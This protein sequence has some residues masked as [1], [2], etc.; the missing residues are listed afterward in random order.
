MVEWLGENE[1]LYNKKKTDYKNVTKKGKLWRDKAAIWGWEPA[2][3]VTWFRSMRTRFGKL[4]KDGEKSGS[5]L[6]HLTDR[7]QWILTSFR[8]MKSHIHRHGSKQMGNLNAS[9]KAYELSQTLK[10]ATKSSRAIRLEDLV[11]DDDESDDDAAVS[12]AVLEGCE[13][14]EGASKSSSS[15]G[16]RVKRSRTHT[17]ESTMSQMATDAAALQEKM[18]GLIK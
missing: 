4:T 18:A 1:I 17:P 7:D 16:P 11:S 6:V 15:K 14:S 10:A 5:D 12:Q 3:L 8:F 2:I 13:P 9:M